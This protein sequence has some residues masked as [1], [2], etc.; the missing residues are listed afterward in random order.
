[1]TKKDKNNKGVLVQCI[2]CLSYD[3]KSH[4]MGMDMIRRD[5]NL[6]M[7]LSEKINPDKWDQQMLDN[8]KRAKASYLK[9]LWF[10]CNSCDFTWQW[11]PEGGLGNDWKAPKRYS[12]YICIK[13][14]SG[15]TGFIMYH[16]LWGYEICANEHLDNKIFLIKDEEHELYEPTLYCFNCYYYFRTDEQE[17]GIYGHT[18]YKR[19][20]IDPDDMPDHW[21]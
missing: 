4:S 2:D 11:L 21:K 17:I 1:M 9:S 13:C 16:P 6:Y 18:K 19:E 14:D 10:Q 8:Y 20:Y 5:K 15:R 3:I 7:S 12:G